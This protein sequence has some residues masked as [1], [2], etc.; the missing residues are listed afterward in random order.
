MAR[1]PKKHL[2][3]LHAPK[4]WMLSKMGG[5]WAPRPSTG[6]HKLRECIPLVLV[7]RNKLKYALNRNEVQTICMR[8]LVKVDG[9]VRMDTNYPTGF[10][11]VISIDKSDEHFRIL[12]DEK[13]RFLLHS[14][15]AEEAK[16]KLLKV[17]KVAKGSKANTGTNPTQAGQAGAIPYVV[18]HDGRTIRYPDPTIKVGDSV[19]FD[20][21]T[22]RITD[23]CAFDVG[24]V[25][26]ITRGANR[27][28]I[29]VLV[30]I[31]KHPGS[32]D[33]VHLKDKRGNTFA[34]RGA[35]AFVIGN[36]SKPDISIPRGKGVKLTVIEQREK[37]DSKKKD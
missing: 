14:M 25:C 23:V 29:G 19:K 5:L 13:G 12:F 15:S 34:T 6:P 9:K 1:G 35:N 11:D 24:N 22:G 2:K 16:F 32:F 27:G 3:R 37:A 8:R 28:R 31:D 21:S 18:T 7:L 33:I 4:T 30:G 10:M 17:A 26:M 36:G 20:I